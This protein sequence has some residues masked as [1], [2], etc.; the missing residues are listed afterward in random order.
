MNEVDR[1]LEHQR[2]GAFCS[3]QGGGDVEAS[4]GE[5]IVEVVAGDA[6]GN[7]RIAGADLIRVAVA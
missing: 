7:V 5:Q 3:G 1:C 6:A 4:L 2:A